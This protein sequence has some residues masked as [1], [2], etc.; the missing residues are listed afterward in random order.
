[1]CLWTHKSGSKYLIKV[2]LNFSAK[3]K[4]TLVAFD[5]V[6]LCYTAYQGMAEEVGS[7]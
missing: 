5:I 3:G 1:M 6:L 7:L 4:T 2:T